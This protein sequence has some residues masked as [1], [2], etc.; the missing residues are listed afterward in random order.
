M[1]EKNKILDLI[2]D[3]VTLLYKLKKGGIKSIDTAL[4]YLVIYATFKTYKGISDVMERKE[5]TANH[6]K[7]SVRTVSNALV[8]LDAEV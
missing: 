2:E 5:E 7:V 4:D 8:L 6:C 1:S 3:N